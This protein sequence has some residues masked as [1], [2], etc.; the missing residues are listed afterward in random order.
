MQIT[1]EKEEKINIMLK[2][3]KKANFIGVWICCYP[4]LISIF[5]MITDYFEL[6]EAFIRLM[7]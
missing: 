3:L 5:Q 6:S 7:F 2:Q 1:T 4:P